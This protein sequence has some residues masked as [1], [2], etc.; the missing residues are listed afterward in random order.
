MVG[1]TMSASFKNSIYTLVMIALGVVLVLVI[2]QPVI[3]SGWI[4]EG[5]ADGLDPKSLSIDKPAVL[6]FKLSGKGGGTYNLMFSKEK[7]EV[8]EGRTDQVDLLITMN[9]ADFNTLIFQ[10]AQGKANKS[11]FM[12]LIISNTMKMAG[13]FSVLQLLAPPDGKNS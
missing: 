2:W 1:V 12:K 10:M 3:P 5:M 13:D 9:A 4:I 7:I 6:C 8:T 11:V